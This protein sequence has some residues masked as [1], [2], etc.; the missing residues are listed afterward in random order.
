[1]PN[2]LVSGEAFTKYLLYNTSTS[3]WNFHID[4]SDLDI[5]S[6]ISI[7]EEPIKGTAKGRKRVQQEYKYSCM[8]N[9]RPKVEELKTIR[10][11][12]T[13]IISHCAEGWIATEEQK[14]CGAYTGRVCSGY[15]T[16]RNYHCFVCNNFADL[17][18]CQ[19]L[20]FDLPPPREGYA[21]SFSMVLDWKRL[22]RNKCAT[23][24]IYDPLSRVCRKV[25]I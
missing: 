3:E 6:G 4:K 11:C 19:Y 20:L 16:Y 1:M 7:R 8:L 2:L 13:G 21:P 5:D 18:E 17:N 14:L 12:K 10:S 25:F 24:E 23:S 15:N 9:F 22:K